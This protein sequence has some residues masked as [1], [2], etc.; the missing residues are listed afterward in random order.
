M[1]IN[2]ALAIAAFLA[3]IFV[4]P[5]IGLYKMFQKGRLSCVEGPDPL[6]EYL[7]YTSTDP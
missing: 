6:P 1:D 5:V 7:V 2:Q 4:L 3:V